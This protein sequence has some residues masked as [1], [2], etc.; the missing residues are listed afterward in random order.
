MLERVPETERQRRLEICTRCEFYVPTIVSCSQCW[1]FL[2][3]KASLK[4]AR[5]PKRRW[6]IIENHLPLAPT[7]PSQDLP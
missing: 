4:S 3:A 6:S 1:C 5:C 2:P 7:L